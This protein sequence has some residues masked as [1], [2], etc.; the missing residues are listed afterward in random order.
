MTSRET[1][2]PPVECTAESYRATIKHFDE[3]LKA[4]GLSASDRMALL[5]RRAAVLD[6]AAKH[7]P[8]VVW[9]VIDA[10]TLE[11]KPPGFVCGADTQ[12]SCCCEGVEVAGE[13]LECEGSDVKCGDNTA[14]LDFLRLINTNTVETNRLLSLILEKNWMACLLLE[15]EK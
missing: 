14:L 3:R 12:R 5:R 10:E 9:P 4:P 1:E 7:H 8:E 2:R 15:K 6:W 13:L 11:Y